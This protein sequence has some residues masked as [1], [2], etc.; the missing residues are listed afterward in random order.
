MKP[1]TAA[2]Q[3]VLDLMCFGKTDKVIA[4]ILDISVVT[5]FGRVKKVRIKLDAENRTQAVAKFW[6]HIYSRGNKCHCQRF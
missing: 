2:E 6:H 3:A 1:I 4:Q 5:V